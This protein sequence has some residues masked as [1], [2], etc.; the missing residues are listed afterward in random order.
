[1]T[2]CVTPLFDLSYLNYL[3]AGFRSNTNEEE[4]AWGRQVLRT[5]LQQLVDFG[6]PRARFGVGSLSTTPVGQNPWLWRQAR[7]HEL[8][9]YCLDELCFSLEKFP[10]PECN[11]GIVRYCVTRGVLSFLWHINRSF[12]QGYLFFFRKILLNWISSLQCSFATIVL[13]RRPRLLQLDSSFF[14]CL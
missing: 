12:R 5:P 4:R 10:V 2:S 3:R 8:V 6:N 9:F 13:R 1:M 11:E 7:V 14:L